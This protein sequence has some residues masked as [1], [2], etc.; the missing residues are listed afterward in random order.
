MR[1]RDF[2]RRMV[3]VGCLLLM[4]GVLLLSFEGT[5]HGIDGEDLASPSSIISALPSTGKG[6]WIWKI[7]DTNGDGI[8]DSGNL[9]SILNRLGSVGV[10]WAVIKL[11]DSDASWLRSGAQ[12]DLWLKENNYGQFSD[13]IVRFHDAGIKVFGWHFVHSYGYWGTGSTEADM[14]KEIL[15]VP[16]I[17]GLVINAE[18]D[19]DQQ[20]KG[21]VAKQYMIGIRNAYPGRFI[22]Y[23][24]FAR[25]DG[26]LWFPWLEFGKYCDANMPQAYWKDRPTTPTEELRRMK[27]QFDKWHQTWTSGGFGDSVKPIFPVGQAYN[28]TGSEISEFCKV[29]YE[30][31]YEGVSLFRYGTMNDEMWA[32]YQFPP[33][34]GEILEVSLSANP[35]QGTAPLDDVDLTAV[36]SGSATGTINY[37]FYSNRAD[38]ETNVTYPNSFKIDHINPDGTDGEVITWGTATDYSGGTTFTVYDVCNYAEPGSYSAK[39]I[40]ERGTKQAQAR[41][42]IIVTGTVATPAFDPVPGTYTSAQ[43]VTMSCATAGA[44]TRYTLDGATPTEGSPLYSSPV[45]I[46]QT[47]TLKAKAFKSGWNSSGVASG[48]YTITGTVATPV[49][50]PVPGTYASAQSVTITSVPWDAVI[51]YTQD[52]SVPTESS[53]VYSAPVSISQTKTLKAKA[54]KTGWNSSG[55]ASGTYT[56]TPLAFSATRSFSPGFYT[57]PGTVDVSIEISYGG[58]DV[59]SAFVIVESIPVGWSFNS[60][61]SCWAPPVICPEP[62]EESV[63]L[64]WLEVADFPAV[65]TYRLNVPAAQSGTKTFLGMGGA[66]TTAG[67]ANFAIGGDQTIGLGIYGVSIDGESGDFVLSWEGQAGKAYQVEASDDLEVWYAASNVVA[68]T[69]DGPVSW[70]DLDSVGFPRRFYRLLLLTD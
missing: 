11:A 25:V 42:E 50:D 68:P 54:F 48:T 8:R 52:G 36:V 45:S 22:A 59:P 31:G 28:V 32:G 44:T 27:E 55:V 41:I 30:Y 16:G 46:S 15:A 12:I 9:T 61:V 34:S 18:T 4:S 33:G 6:I 62:G 14:A 65:L 69:A 35:P 67:Q 23:S 38:D 64:G 26:H 49:F 63:A 66:T 43:S 3:R 19:Y 5:S 60:L 17:D 10:E 53:P 13:V 7:F 58:S 24:S 57:S 51:H 21:E 40:A 29:A 37:T 70:R 39:V 20:G 56:I 2:V 47:T 1:S